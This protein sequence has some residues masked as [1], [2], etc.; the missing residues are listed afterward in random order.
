VDP[1][2]APVIIRLWSV[3]V[4]VAAVSLGEVGVG[5]S[6]VRGGSDA[7]AQR[8]SAMTFYGAT[9]RAAALLTAPPAGPTGTPLPCPVTVPNG[10]TPPG[11]PANALQHGNGRLWTE[12]W[13]EGTVLIEP[14]QVQPDGTLTM[15]WPWWRGEHGHLTIDGQHLDR[16]A[17]PLQADI[18]EGYGETGFQATALI[19]PTDGCWEV[20]GRIGDA[21][22]TF[23]VLVIRVDE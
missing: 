2:A 3:V 6:A 11:E 18:P 12:F 14:E 8:S 4:L 1:G 21:S 19:F 13:P 9:A 7:S 10:R 20:T 17:P 5:R 23:V 22:L 16:P 15:K